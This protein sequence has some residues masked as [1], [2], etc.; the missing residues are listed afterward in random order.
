MAGH[1]TALL[2]KDARKREKKMR[3][4]LRV[5]RMRPGAMLDFYPALKAKNEPCWYIRSGP[6]GYPISAV[7]PSPREAWKSAYDTLMQATQKPMSIKK[8]TP[9][10]GSAD[11]D[12]LPLPG[13]GDK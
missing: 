4:K 6:N 1:K 3:H 13:I 7:T 5:W 2:T 10:T 12:T 8:T 11:H 9:R